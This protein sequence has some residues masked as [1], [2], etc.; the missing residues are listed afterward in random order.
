[1]SD[2]TPE[3]PHR[4]PWV[5]AD[6][7]RAGVDPQRRPYAFKRIIGN[8]LLAALAVA[9]AAFFVAP[10]VAFFAIR[11]AAE[12]KDI[13]GL[14]RLIDFDDVRASLRPQ[15]SVRP[16]AQTPPPS[17]M[18]D[19]IGAMRRQFEDAVVAP[20]PAP[21]IEAYLTPAALAALTAGDGRS[22]G[23]TPRV[24]TAPE[25]WPRPAYWG[26]N[27]AR[28]SVTDP[29]GA[30]TLF[31]FERRGPFEWKLVHIGLPDGT[32][33]AAAPRAPSGRN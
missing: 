7:R 13:A 12:A 21:D 23:R 3:P 15:L 24:T 30:R 31:T 32:A 9:V 20:V 28:L 16:A 26:V 5:V 11:S 33:P 27:R 29:G 2:P 8:L 4:S 25:P 19:P 18:Q 10:A 17:F 14:T 6:E 22:A 1:M